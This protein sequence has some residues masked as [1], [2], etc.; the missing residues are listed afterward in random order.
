MKGNDC[1]GSPTGQQAAETAPKA[2]PDC[3][4]RCHK[5]TQASV[6]AQAGRECSLDLSWTV[7]KACTG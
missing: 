5:A 2:S 6:G 7:H 1:E 3:S 4:W